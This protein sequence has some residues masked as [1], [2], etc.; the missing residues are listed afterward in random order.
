MKTYKVEVIIREGCDEFWEE[1]Q[2]LG[3][4]GVDEI[5]QCVLE[6]V[7]NSGFPEAEVNIVEFTDK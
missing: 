2:S 7:Y 1:L 6:A 4:S 3:K 5:R